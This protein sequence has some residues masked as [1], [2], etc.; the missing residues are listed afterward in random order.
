MP[1]P[2]T[3]SGLEQF[4][5]RK[6]HPSCYKHQAAPIEPMIHSVPYRT[7]ETRSWV[8]LPHWLLRQTVNLKSRIDLG[9]YSC[10]LKDHTLSTKSRKAVLKMDASVSK[11]FPEITVTI[12]TFEQSARTSLGKRSYIGVAFPYW[13]ASR[14]TLGWFI[15]SK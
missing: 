7:D 6:Y 8:G 2:P 1:P 9:D 4:I 5:Q 12:P 3:S 14:T 11:I 10:N 15:V 13:G